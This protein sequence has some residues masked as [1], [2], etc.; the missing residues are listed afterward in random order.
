RWAEYFNSLLNRSSSVDPKALDLVPQQPIKEDLD[1]PPSLSE[2]K[3]AI[4]QMNTGKAPGKD[5]IMAEIYKAASPKTI[6]ILY[7]IL[8][9]VWEVEEMPKD[10]KDATIIPLFKNKGSKADCGNYQGISLLSIAG[11]ILAR[12]ILNWLT[13]NI[14]ENTLPE[15]QCG[16]RPGRNMIDMIFVV[17]QQ[18][19]KQLN[20][21]GR[22]CLQMTVPYLLINKQSDLQII[23]KFS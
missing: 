7:N 14:S 8:S 5:G 12:I 6:E 17:R 9:S 19:L 4:S 18:R 2:V 10:F 13:S 22:P 23:V 21:F 3:T 16:F 1:L 15:A 20:S 11:K